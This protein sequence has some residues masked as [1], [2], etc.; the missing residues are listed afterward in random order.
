MIQCNHGE[1][2]K[3]TNTYKFI[4]L[5]V[6]LYYILI[7]SLSLYFLCEFSFEIYI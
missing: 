1:E 4:N 2:E 3:K 5:Q 7:D 6:Y